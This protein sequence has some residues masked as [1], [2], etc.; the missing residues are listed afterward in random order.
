MASEDAFQPWLS[1]WRLVP[2]GEAVSTHSSLLLPVQSDGAPAMLKIATIEEELNGAHLM[3][4]YAGNGSARV[5]AHEGAGLLLERLGGQRSLIEMERS[6]RGTGNEDHLRGRREAARRERPHAA[7]DA[8]SGWPRFD[9]VRSGGTRTSGYAPRRRSAAWRRPSS[10][11]RA[12]LARHRPERSASAS[13]LSTTPTCPAT[14]KPGSP[15]KLAS[16]SGG[17]TSW[18]GTRTWIRS[19]SSSGSWPIQA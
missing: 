16:W 18:Q 5:L 13:E 14:P 10:T 12:W 6:G 15:W 19:D 7:G 1:R 17:S 2:D 9:K 8:V 11:G 4:W 3:A